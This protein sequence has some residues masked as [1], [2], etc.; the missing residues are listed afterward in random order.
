V[1]PF[2]LTKTS[3]F[4]NTRLLTMA[5][6]QPPEPML[7]MYELTGELTN[8]GQTLVAFARTVRELRGEFAI[9]F[10]LPA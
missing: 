10:S 6:A 8:Q 1:R 3:L 5:T 2:H 4:L 9:E 7:G